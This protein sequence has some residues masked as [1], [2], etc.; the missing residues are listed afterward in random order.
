[1]FQLITLLVNFYDILFDLNIG[2]YKVIPSSFILDGRNG[3][4]IKKFRARSI[5]KKRARLFVRTRIFSRMAMRFLHVPNA[6][7]AE[8]AIRA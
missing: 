1:M 2:F 5:S 7:M 3:L 8:R 4:G 6:K